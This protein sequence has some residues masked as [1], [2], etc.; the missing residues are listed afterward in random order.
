MNSSKLKISK[1]KITNE[2]SQIDRRRN[3]ETHIVKFS[4]EEYK[5]KAGKG[6]KLITGKYE[7]FAYIQLNPKS[8]ATRNR[9]DA[10]DVFKSI[11]H[12]EK[13]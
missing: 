4:G 5:N 8:T 9:K 13:K 10:L 7:P 6:D 11:M 3:R 1:R 2:K 12:P